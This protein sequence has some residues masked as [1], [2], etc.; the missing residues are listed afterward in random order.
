M[1]GVYMM[2][3]PGG[4]KVPELDVSAHFQYRDDATMIERTKYRGTLTRG[5]RLLNV[6]DER[7]ESGDGRYRSLCFHGGDVDRTPCAEAK[8][9]ARSAGSMVDERMTP[10]IF[11]RARHLSLTSNHHGAEFGAFRIPAPSCKSPMPLPLAESAAA[12]VRKARDRAE[13]AGLVATSEVLPGRAV[14]AI[15]DCRNDHSFDAIVLGTEGS[16]GLELLFAGSTADCVLRHSNVPVFVVPPGFADGVPSFTRTLVAAD[17]SEPSDAAVAFA[18]DFAAAN[19]ASL[20]I[21]TVAETGRLL[22]EAEFTHPTLRSRSQKFTKRPGHSSRA[23][24]CAPL[25]KGAE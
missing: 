12:I 13:K 14:G 21:G 23:F 4:R 3:V 11:V 9:R 18:I 6:F 25:G 17:D 7:F 19:H 1:L 20:A 16:A 8:R 5:I 24:S 22:L 10:A 15:L 2:V